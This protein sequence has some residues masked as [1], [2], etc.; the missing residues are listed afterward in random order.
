MNEYQHEGMGPMEMSV[1]AGKRC[2]AAVAYLRPALKRGNIRVIKHAKVDKVV[3]EGLKA[4]GV[5]F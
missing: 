4:V 1:K 2:S 3:F 5:A